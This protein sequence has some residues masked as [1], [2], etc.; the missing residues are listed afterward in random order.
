M[1]SLP[2]LRTHTSSPSLHPKRAG[3]GT[4][5]ADKDDTLY[6]PAYSRGAAVH[7]SGVFLWQR[8]TPVASMLASATTFTEKSAPT[9]GG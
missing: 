6:I 1:M 7:A 4:W 2:Y 5:A 3:D 9:G 8:R